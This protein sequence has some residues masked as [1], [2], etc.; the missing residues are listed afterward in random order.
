VDVLP[1]GEPRTIF[2]GRALPA[3]TGCHKGGPYIIIRVLSLS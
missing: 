1:G 3:R 2:K